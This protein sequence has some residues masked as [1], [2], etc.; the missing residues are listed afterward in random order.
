M[1]TFLPYP[2]FVDSVKCLDRQRL[3]KQ[4][5][6]AKQLLNVLASSGKVGWKNHPAAL[7]WK[8]HEFALMEY[9]NACLRE[10]EY[11]GYKNILLKP[12]IMTVGTITYPSW[13][14]NKDF[15][16]AHRSNLLR[17]NK[18]HYKQFGWTEPDDLPYVWPVR[19]DI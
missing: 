17:K 14:G 3:G 9:Y 2:S 13:L 19:K 18:E 15:H 5:V 6:E 10:W 12:Y 7:M 4:R 16:A 1:Q 11:R 8:G